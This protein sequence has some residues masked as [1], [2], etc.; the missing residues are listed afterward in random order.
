MNSALEGFKSSYEVL[1]SP[2]SEM[3]ASTMRFKV[4]F[5]RQAFL[6][7]IAA[8]K[9][10]NS[11][12]DETQRPPKKLSAGQ[13]LGVSV[14]GSPEAWIKFYEQVPSVY[15]EYTAKVQKLFE[16]YCAAF[17]PAAQR[18]ITTA[19]NFLFQRYGKI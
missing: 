18:E 6:D 13:L 1:G 5:N 10:L 19:A 17:K 2:G 16:K 8:G 9:A 4:P 14:N 11:L 7:V 3:I 12:I 15:R